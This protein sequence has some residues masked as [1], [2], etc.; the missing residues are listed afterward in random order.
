VD[1]VAVVPAAPLGVTAAAAGTTITV[2]WS[3]SSGMAGYTVERSADGTTGW[4]QVGTT[5]G[6]TTLA[7]AGLPNATTYHY[8][9]IAT[10]GV[11][12]SAPSAAASATTVPAAPAGMTATA[13]SDTLI[14]LSWADVSAET[15]YLVERSADGTGGWTTAGT[16]A[17][18]RRRSRSAG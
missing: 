11:G 9:V 3:A 6:A 5:T 14:S 10:S 12:D 8:R 2:N 15:G 16:V 7:D 4:G 1:D 13:V 18:T 17:A